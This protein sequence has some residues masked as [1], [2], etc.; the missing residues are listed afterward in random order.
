MKPTIKISIIAAITLPFFL[1][2]IS[3]SV[4]QTCSDESQP[5]IIYRNAGPPIIIENA[6][7][8]CKEAAKRAQKLQRK[9]AKLA[10]KLELEAAQDKE[11]KVD[12]R[13]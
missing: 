8:P 9:H 6:I 10:R 3:A 7:N 4:G 1:A 12:W 13:P 11:V 2:C 5:L